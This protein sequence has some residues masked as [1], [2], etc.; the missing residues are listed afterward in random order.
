[1]HELIAISPLLDADGNE[2]GLYTSTNFETYKHKPTKKKFTRGAAQLYTDDLRGKPAY[3]KDIALKPKTI[4]EENCED[5]VGS[6]T[7]PLREDAMHLIN[8]YVSREMMKS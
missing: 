5:W 6:S 4:E 7:K 2:T 1:M 3:Y 8:A